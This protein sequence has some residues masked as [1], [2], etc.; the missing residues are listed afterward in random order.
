M[1]HI[2]YIYLKAY[3]LYMK[4]IHNLLCNERYTRSS[5]HWSEM[6]QNT[7]MHHK[8]GT[9]QNGLDENRCIKSP[10]NCNIE[11]L[12]EYQ[13]MSQHDIYTLHPC[14]THTQYIY[15]MCIHNKTMALHLNN[16]IFWQSN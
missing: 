6:A 14:L 13:I 9:R 16:Q 3:V 10:D 11:Y 8:T 15:Q 5:T 12:L 2:C 4:T 1:K 7:I